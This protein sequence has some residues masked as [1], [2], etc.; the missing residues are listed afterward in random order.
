MIQRLLPLNICSD[1]S[2]AKFIVSPC[3]ALAAKWVLESP[4]L[5]GNKMAYVWGEFGKTHISNIF[6]HLHGGLVIN[7]SQMEHPRSF[8]KKNIEAFAIDS[9][10]FFEEMWLFDAFNILKER[11]SFALYTSNL[12]PHNFH[13]HD[14]KSR[15]LSIP[16]FRLCLPDDD[17]IKNIAIKRLKDLGSS[18]DNDTLTYLLNR[19]PRNWCSINHWI[20]KLDIYSSIFKR[21]ISKSM[22]N[23]LLVQ[24]TEE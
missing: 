14:L 1:Y 9:V 13:L 21:K 10:D 23:D 4:R 7:R 5:A 17:F 16:S 2:L 22:V 8:F 15:M 3:N 6:A 11:N 19:I 12:S 20:E 18:I 24:T